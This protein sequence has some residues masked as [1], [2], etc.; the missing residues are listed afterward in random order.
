M[1]RII[2]R[3]VRS[4]MRLVGKLQEISDVDGCLNTDS[5]KMHKVQDEWGLLT[6]NCLGSKCDGSP[7]KILLQPLPSIALDSR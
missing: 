1:T 2:T 4:F 7:Y 6:G 5:M 3:K